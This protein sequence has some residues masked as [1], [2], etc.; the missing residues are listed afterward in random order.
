MRYD[1]CQVSV[2]IGRDRRLGDAYRRPAFAAP[3][4]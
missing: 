4:S 1:T 2:T 3:P